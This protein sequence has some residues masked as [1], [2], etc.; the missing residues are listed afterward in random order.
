[1]Y[2]QTYVCREHLCIHVHTYTCSIELQYSGFTTPGRMQG[3]WKFLSNSYA[4]LYQAD[5]YTPAYIDIH[6]YNIHV[7]ASKQLSA[8]SDTKTFVAVTRSLSGMV[9]EGRRGH[10]AARARAT[11]F[12]FFFVTVRCYVI[13]YIFS[14]CNSLFE[15]NIYII[16]MQYASR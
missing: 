9:G 11:S 5:V 7:V 13:R 1:M 12:A 8:G 2:I 4:Y 3:N 16:C 10:R 6:M 14:F 15:M